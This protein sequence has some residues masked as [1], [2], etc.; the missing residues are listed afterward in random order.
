MAAASRERRGVCFCVINIFFLC[1]FLN[2]ILYLVIT[3]SLRSFLTCLLQFYSL[4]LEIV[5]NFTHPFHT[6][7]HDKQHKFLPLFCWNMFRFLCS[8][9]A[10]QNYIPQIFFL[11]FL[12][13]L[14]PLIF[15]CVLAFVH[16]FRSSCTS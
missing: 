8:Q 6:C 4:N 1:F 7:V 16:V 14:P 13:P 5:N 12:T 9:P 11:F 3:R 10:G 2:K 15:G